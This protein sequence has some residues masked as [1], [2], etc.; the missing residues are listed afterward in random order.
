MV[1]TIFN[2]SLNSVKNSNCLI[3]GDKFNQL[4]ITEKNIITLSCGHSFKYNYYISSYFI[5]KESNNHIYCPY[6]KSFITNV[7]F[8]IKTKLLNRNCLHG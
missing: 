4:D 2:R 3:S 7:P 8:I 5:S 1:K 6:C